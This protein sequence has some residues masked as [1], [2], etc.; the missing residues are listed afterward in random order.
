MFSIFVSMSWPR[1]IYVVSVWTI[2]HFQPYFPCH[3]SHNL[4][5]TDTIVFC[6]VFRI[7]MSYYFGMINWMKNANY[8]QIVKV[9]LRLL[10]SFCLI[11]CLF[12]PGVAY[13]SA[14]KKACTSKLRFFKYRRP[15]I[16]NNFWKD[17]LCLKLHEL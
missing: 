10:L 2:F 1:S 16:G 4:I 13:K 14:Y 9:S 6:T 15:I 7:Y 17:C 3:W 8:F 12:Q 5:E 11:F